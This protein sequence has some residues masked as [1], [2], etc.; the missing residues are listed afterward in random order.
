MLLLT[1]ARNVVAGIAACRAGG[2]A[3]SVDETGHCL[4]LLLRVPFG[5][6][7]VDWYFWLGG[8]LGLVIVPGRDWGSFCLEKAGPTCLLS[9]E[10]PTSGEARLT[11]AI[12]GAFSIDELAIGIYIMLL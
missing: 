8:L 6:C 12:L 7:E 5:C 9:S 11:R 1:S 4:L 3:R 10:T 2:Q